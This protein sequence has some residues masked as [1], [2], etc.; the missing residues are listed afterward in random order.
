DPHL[1]W[2]VATGRALEAGEGLAAVGRHVARGVE[3]VDPV[4]I[5]RVDVDAAVVAA[6]TVADARVVGGHLPPGRAA[7]VGA[8][9]T[10]VADDEDALTA[11][12]VGDSDPHLAGDAGGECV[13]GNFG[14]ADAI[15]Y[16]F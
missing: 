1:L 6:L 10:E 12:V 8:V 13:A 3:G 9:E 4:G 11:G 2:I 16:G 7:V 14:P 5:V 15:V